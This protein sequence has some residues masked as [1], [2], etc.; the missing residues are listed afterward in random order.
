MNIDTV[1]KRFIEENID[2]IE[3]HEYNQLFNNWNTQVAEDNFFDED[4]WLKQLFEILTSVGISE[5][6][7]YEDR[8]QVLIQELTKATKRRLTFPDHVI[9]WDNLLASIPSHLGFSINE[10]YDLLNDDIDLPEI[11]PNKSECVYKVNT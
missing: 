10:L 9:F 8:K 1:L 6:Q 11:T 4:S 5:E 2:L 3:K 7:T